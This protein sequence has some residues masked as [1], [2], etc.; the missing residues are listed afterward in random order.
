MA[1]ES[2]QPFTHQQFGPPPQPRPQVA[3]T[4][5]VLPASA[6]PG[7]PGT[8]GGRRGT[9]ILAAAAIAVA[10]VAAT[11]WAAV[12]L[13][14]GSGEQ[15]VAALP[16]DSLA[17]ATIDLD[18]SAAQKVSA[19]RFFA[20]FPGETARDAAGADDLRQAFYEGITQA[21][22][23]APP[24]SE[25]DP[26]LGDRVGIALRPPETAGG[27]PY[28]VIALQVRD[29]D[30]A[31]QSLQGM[32]TMGGTPVGVAGDGDW[33]V[34]ADT[35][36]RATAAWTAARVSPLAEDADYR[37]DLA[38][39]GAA[40]VATFWGDFAGLSDLTLRTAGAPAPAKPLQG[41]GAATLRFDGDAL[42]LVGGMRVAEAAATRA[43]GTVTVNAPEDVAALVAV[44]GLGDL[45]ADQW[46]EAVAQL[47]VTQSDLSSMEQMTGLELPEDLR[48]LLGRQMLLAVSGAPAK[49]VVGL[50][51]VSDGPELEARLAV[52][53]RQFAKTGQD[54][55]TRRT[56]DGY[57]VD[58]F[59]GVA[60]LGEDGG[61]AR[62]QTF[63]DA[64]P[65]AESAQL[66]AYLNVARAIEL[67]GDAVSQA[68]L[69]NLAPF[70]A[71]GLSVR[72]DDDSSS[73]FRLRFTTR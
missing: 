17:A 51:V 48:I 58:L 60:D 1:H 64:V 71:V 55:T 65:D 40:G 19:L 22:P 54:V 27:D 46:A 49:P 4:E 68:D 21:S 41:H 23:A 53:Q 5:T 12:A 32:G 47:K 72:R 16:A 61:L 57:V 56:G 67:G 8:G 31:R 43:A 11:A 39:L 33:V 3:Y 24:W 35:P 7:R 20:K 34:L 69:A 2:H 15:A 9:A 28:P 63:V 30:A 10:G 73:S 42:E 45:I 62:S 38:E 36:Q 59:G 66:V 70:R 13:W 14:T 52:V 6:S 44:S 50:H 25:V 29:A 18:P 37:S 26:W